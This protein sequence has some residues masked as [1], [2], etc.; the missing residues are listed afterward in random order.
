MISG[1]GKTAPSRVVSDVQKELTKLKGEI[2]KADLDVIVH[3]TKKELLSEWAR[4]DQQFR[5][6]I[7]PIAKKLNRSDSDRVLDFCFHSARLGTEMLGSVMLDS[8][9]PRN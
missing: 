9:L 1:K 6:Q 7:V 2:S 8:G 4:L 5:G 3:T